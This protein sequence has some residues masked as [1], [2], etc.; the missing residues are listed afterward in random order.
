MNK[1]LATNLISA[2]LIGLAYLTP[3]YKDQL[4]AV[5][6]FATSGAFTN[7]LASHMLFERVPGLYG[8]GV[9]PARFEEFKTGIRTLIMSQFFTVENVEAFFASEGESDGHLL[10][11]DPIVEAIDYDHIYWGFVDVVMGSSF[12]GMLGM[13]GG[14]KA[15]EPLRVPFKEKMRDEV[16]KILISPQFA[17]AIQASLNSSHL[18]ED[19]IEKADYI[20]TRRLDELTPE[21]VKQII[22]E[23]IREHLGWLV[24][25]GG[26]FGG[27]LGLIASF[28]R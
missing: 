24:I 1:S 25:W 19:I 8:S 17:D 11:P 18:A 21:L 14:A 4:L 23:M 15:L 6:L 26:V 13:V 7:W 5:G 2:S 10:N 12:G 20:V 27:I 9:I 16:Y 28:F 22:Q 3:V